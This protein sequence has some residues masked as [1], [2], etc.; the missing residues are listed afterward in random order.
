MQLPAQQQPRPAHGGTGVMWS[1][2][3][4]RNITGACAS[5]RQASP[6]QARRSDLA[7]GKRTAEDSRR[8]SRFS[9]SVIRSWAQI[10]TYSQLCKPLPNRRLRASCPQ[11]VALVACPMFHG[12]ETLI[13]QPP[14]NPR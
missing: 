6:K 1:G 9:G 8:G 11:L 10:T 13:T 12:L 2:P 3:S 4:W 5:T 7:G 14:I